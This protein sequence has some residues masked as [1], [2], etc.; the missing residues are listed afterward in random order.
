MPITTRTA[1]HD[2]Q[3]TPVSALNG[4]RLTLKVDYTIDTGDPC[5]IFGFNNLQIKLHNS[6]PGW[7]LVTSSTN[8]SYN[9]RPKPDCVNRL[10]LN[11]YQDELN[12]WGAV[13]AEWVTPGIPTPWGSIGSITIDTAQIGLH[14]LI[15]PDGSI[16]KS[17]T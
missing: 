16:K 17:V 6:G 8:H 5:K 15:R 2:H 10:G 12:V 11:G 14:M 13:N 7:R 9:L 3:Y 4:F 1:T